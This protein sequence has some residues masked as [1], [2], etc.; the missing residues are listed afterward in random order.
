MKESYKEDDAHHF[1]PE[2]CLDDPRGRGEA[3]TGESTTVLGRSWGNNRGFGVLCPVFLPYPLFF[4]LAHPPAAA[5]NLYG[6]DFP[7]FEPDV[8]ALRPARFF[9]GTPT[10][11]ES[12]RA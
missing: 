2:L 8:K 7:I 3:L 5:Y 10:G 9:C 6:V 11:T 12:T 4:L 1:G